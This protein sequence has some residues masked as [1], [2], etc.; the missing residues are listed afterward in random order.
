M[1]ISRV[2]SLPL[3]A[4]FVGNDGG[5]SNVYWVSSGG[6]IITPF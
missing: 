6:S 5:L 2:M 3:Q 1:T 4:S